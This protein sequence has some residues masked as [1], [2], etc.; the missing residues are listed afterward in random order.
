[1]KHTK[2][3]LVFLCFIILGPILFL[4]SGCDKYTRYKV[5]T[6]FFTGVPHPDGIIEYLPQKAAKGSNMKEGKKEETSRSVH[7]PYA[8]ERCYLCH[9][10]SSARRFGKVEDTKRFDKGLP[11]KLLSPVNTLCIECHTSKTMESAFSKNLWIHGPVSSG[12]CTICHDPHETQYRYLLRQGNSDQMC[13]MCHASE[14]IVPSEDH[15]AGEECTKCHNAHLGKN[16]FL[17]KKEFTE[18]Y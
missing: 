12:M 5:S 17:L 9:E 14:F 18:K 3:N 8:A 15:L 7:G 6:F 11:G 10:I 1:M 2:Y 4:F 16:R 13:A